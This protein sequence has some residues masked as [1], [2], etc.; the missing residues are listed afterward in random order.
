MKQPVKQE[1]ASEITVASPGRI[2]LIGEHVDYN[3]GFVLPAAIDKCLYL[4][5]RANGHKSRCTIKS[6][7]FESIL[8]VD[9]EH[10]DKGTEGWHNYVLGVIDEIQKL[11]EK[12]RGF[13]CEMVSEVPVGSGV[14]SSAALECGIAFGLNELFNLGLDRWKLAFIGQR[15]EHNF[16]GTKCGIMDQFASVMGKGGHVML[17]DCRSLY[18][19]YIPMNIHPYCLLL[20]N[21]N[22]S[23]NLS[24][25]E[26]NV[27]RKQCEEGL[28]IISNKYNIEKSFRNITREMLIGAKE[29]LPQ[30]LF[31]RCSYVIEEIQRVLDVVSALKENDLTTVG[32]LIYQSHQGLSEKYEVSCDELDFLVQFSKNDPQVLGARMMGGGFGG[33]TLNLIHEDAVDAFVKKAAMAYKKEFGIELSHF[34][35][36]PSLGTHLIQKH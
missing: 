11:T 3:D 6:K 1:T 14:S 23:H 9:I 2:N 22:V 21:T 35:T 30:P 24:T 25:G 26:Y 28:A 36:V 32:E 29:D 7:G 33:C 17:L 31:D 12:L 8:V 10:L 34:Q 20:L 18:F 13:D 19:E 5:M 16:V 27:R 15:A 4:T